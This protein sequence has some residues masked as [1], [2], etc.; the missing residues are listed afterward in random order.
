MNENGVELSI[1]EFKSAQKANIQ[2]KQQESKSIR[3]NNC[4]KSVYSC[5]GAEDVAM[6]MNWI[7]K[8]ISCV[9][10]ELN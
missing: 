10:C 6:G 9:I 8:T 5:L 4:L 7:G 2:V 3:L 1:F